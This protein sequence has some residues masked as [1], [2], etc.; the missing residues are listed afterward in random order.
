MFPSLCRE[1]V[2]SI[3]ELRTGLEN[4][5]SYRMCSLALSTVTDML[6]HFENSEPCKQRMRDL[7]LE[8]T[9]DRLILQESG[10]VRDH[11]LKVRS[12]SCEIRV[13]TYDKI[14][15]ILVL[16]LL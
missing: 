14:H 9:L 11:V 12:M 2:F 16:L 13:A 7:H 3:L 10:I 6:L 8:A 4:V 5:F 15:V 1:N